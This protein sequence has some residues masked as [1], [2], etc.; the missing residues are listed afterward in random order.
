MQTNRGYISIKD[1]EV[2]DQ[3]TTLDDKG[4]KIWDTVTETWKN[5][6]SDIVQIKLKNGSTHESTLEHPWLIQQTEVGLKP[7]T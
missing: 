6:P 5:S 1:V 4:N 7:K 3:I 2:G